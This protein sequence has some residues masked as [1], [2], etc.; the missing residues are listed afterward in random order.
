MKTNKDRNTPLRS[1]CFPFKTRTI[2]NNKVSRPC[3]PML[4]TFGDVNHDVLQQFGDMG[5]PPHERFL[6]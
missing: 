1:A 6:L 3:N 5:L 4:T 2:T